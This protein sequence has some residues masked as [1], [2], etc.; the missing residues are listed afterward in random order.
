LTTYFFGTNLEKKLTI[1]KFLDFQH[2]LQREILSLEVI[3]S[4]VLDTLILI[5]LFAVSTKRSWRKWK[6]HRGRLH[7][8]AV[9]LCWI[10]TKEEE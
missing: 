2:Q 3:L 6:H 10:P 7:G 8:V 9:G 1:E 4:R 5:K